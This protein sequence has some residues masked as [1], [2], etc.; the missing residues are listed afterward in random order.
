MG[1]VNVTPDSFS[2][3][4]AHFSPAAAIAH[5]REL[6]AQG[7][8]MLDIGGESTRPGAEPVSEDEELRRV[9]P[10]IDGLRDAGVPLSIDTFKPN[11]ARRALN[12]GAS[13]INDISG[14]RDDAM[15]DVLA[16]TGAQACV[17]HMQG[18]P[19]TMQA[20][21]RYDDVGAE[22][23]DELESALQRVERRGVAREKLM[24]DPGI[25]FGKTAQHNLFLLQRA[26]DLRLLGAPV[27][28]GVSRKGFLG[29]LTGGK[30]AS[31]RVVASASVA[32][33]LASEGAV[34]WVRVHDVSETK[35][36]LAVGDAIRLARDGGKR[37]T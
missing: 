33:I 28:I 30:A 27:L 31:E 29:A 15:L 2:D 16:E 17:M 34:D 19:K 9:L 11:V 8:D 35:D 14:L 24:V 37:F 12:A 6:I 36:A 32:A 13:L 26:A 7:A 23:L 20:D 18:S 1:I 25:G 4:G 3:G 22:V 21:P 10:V 5:G